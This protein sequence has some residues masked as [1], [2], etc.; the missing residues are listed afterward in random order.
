[1]LIYNIVKSCLLFKIIILIRKEEQIEKADRKYSRQ[2]S[3]PQP[4]FQSFDN[5][6]WM[7]MDNTKTWQ[8]S[9]VNFNQPY[10]LQPVNVN[11]N[12]PYNMQNHSTIINRTYT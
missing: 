6:M 11:F 2:V 1:M 3:I 9:N 12:Q 8:P 7:E 5:N 4:N 10:N